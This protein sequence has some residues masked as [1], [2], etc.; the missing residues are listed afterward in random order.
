GIF[1]GLGLVFFFEFTDNSVHTPQDAERS[2]GLPIIGKI[3]SIRSK[4]NPQITNS[5]LFIT[6]N[7]PT[8][9]SWVREFY[10]ESFRM[11][12]S[13]LVFSFISSDNNKNK[14]SFG[15]TLL[16]T[17]SLPN[18]GKS[19][20]A[21]NLAISMAQIGKKVLLVDADPSDSD[22]FLSGLLDN[23]SYSG[24]VD[25]LDGKANLNAVL[26]KTSIDNL[27]VM[28]LGT[29]GDSDL[30]FLLISTKFDDIIK[31]L[32][33]DF[34][35]ILFKSAP[36]TLSSQPMTIGSKVDGVILVV[37]ADYTKKD[38]IL[39]SSWLLQNS[40]ANILGIVLNRLKKS[41]ANTI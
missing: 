5:P 17:S 39:H 15:K 29:N 14:D 16:I 28:T 34:D 2:I 21:I 13:W 8:K 12:Q 26:T 40:G 6:Y 27:Y 10:K 41:V 36:V 37:R 3:P 25:V 20:V 18:E 19:V 38:I 33:K 31:S 32:K 1:L 35:I 24:L 7:N 4:K 23:N 9:K 22:H 30:S 11:L